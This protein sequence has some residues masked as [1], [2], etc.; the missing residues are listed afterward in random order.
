MVEIRDGE[1]CRLP[2][3]ATGEIWARTPRS[4]N[5]EVGPNTRRD[6]DGFVAT[7][8]VGRLDDDGFLYITGRAAAQETR[9]AG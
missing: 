7:A 4:L 8:D 1:G 5:C 3:N 6:A 2:P 9:A